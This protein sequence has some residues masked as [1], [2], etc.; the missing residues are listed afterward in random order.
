MENEMDVSRWVDD[1]LASLDT[2]R[3]WQPNTETALVRLHSR[4]RVTSR[5]RWI[6]GLATAAAAGLLLLVQSPQACANP[7]GCAAS[8]WQ[9][10]F[11]AQS[12]TAPAGRYSQ[13]ADFKE[14]GSGSAPV[15]CEIYSD[16]QCPACA[17]LYSQVLPVLVE[18]YVKTGKVKLVHRDFPLPMHRYARLAARYANAAGQI[19]R[20][21]PVVDQI[22]RTQDLWKQDGSIDVQ[23]AQ[24]LKP[25]EMA[26]V[27]EIVER[28][29][30]LDGTVAADVAEARSANL[31]ATPTLVI[32]AGS[33]RQVIPG[34]PALPLLQSYLD[35]LLAQ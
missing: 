32:T 35:Q 4:S 13:V 19:G 33:K 34:V 16:Y 26:K 12:R 14:A 31:N 23:V 10:M 5:R 25:S 20:Y 28:D 22:F 24:V 2:D 17:Q 7:R 8:L 27:R 30:A 15:V 1:R 21:D 29:A 9:K 11:L 6:Y 3:R 18:Q